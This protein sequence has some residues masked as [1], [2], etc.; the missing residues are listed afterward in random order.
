MKDGTFNAVIKN[1]LSLS[2]HSFG[3]HVIEKVLKEGDH[4][5]RKEVVESV[6]GTTRYHEYDL[7]ST[8]YDISCDKFGNYVV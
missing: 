4:L 6:I 7:K 8:L 3:S 5:Q 2:K 1:L